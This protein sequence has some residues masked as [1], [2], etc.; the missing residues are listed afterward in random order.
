MG[1]DMPNIKQS[2]WANQTG[3]TQIYRCMQQVDYPAIL[4]SYDIDTPPAQEEPIVA[5]VNMARSTNQHIGICSHWPSNSHLDMGQIYEIPLAQK[6]LVI[7]DIK[8]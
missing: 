8:P 6:R 1:H 2:T 7:S 4:A 3:F 5:S